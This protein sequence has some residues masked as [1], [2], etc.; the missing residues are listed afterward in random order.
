MFQS[1]LP[2]GE[3]LHVIVGS[4]GCGCFNPRSLAGSD[5]LAPNPRN[6]Q[7]VSIHA[8]LRGATD[9]R[10]QAHARLPVSIHAP[11]RGAT[12]I[13]H[14]RR[15]D[16]RVSIHAPLRGATF[17]AR[18]MSFSLRFQSTLP[19]GERHLGLQGHGIL[20][21]FQSTL[22]CG[23][24]RPCMLVSVASEPFQSTLPCGE[25]PVSVRAV[26]CARLSFN[27][28]SLAGSDDW[29]ACCGRNRESVSIHAPLRGATRH[30]FMAL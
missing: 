29:L 23:E 14:P 21:R 15:G 18:M 13:H 17:I 22:P 9:E 20:Y 3:R 6:R 28:R 10:W 4:W 25:R 26:T 19:C 16:S 1:T 30:P 7:G 2:C 8:P 12:A 24:R 5:Y 27:P 11:L